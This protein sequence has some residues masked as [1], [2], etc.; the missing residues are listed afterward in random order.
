[1]GEKPEVLKQYLDVQQ[2]LTGIPADLA[3]RRTEVILGD[4]AQGE[5]IVRS[6]S[7]AIKDAKQNPAALIMQL[8]AASHS[9]Y[10]KMRKQAV[11]GGK[12]FP[13]RS[14]RATCS[15]N[16]RTARASLPGTSMR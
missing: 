2:L 4:Y 14:T 7:D 15:R 6:A 11:K 13:K 5:D 10:L 9:P 8:F 1:M 16:C 12:S 3:A